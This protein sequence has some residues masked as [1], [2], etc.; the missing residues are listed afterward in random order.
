MQLSHLGRSHTIG[1][2]GHWSCLWFSSAMFG[3]ALSGGMPYSIRNTSSNSLTSGIPSGSPA[4]STSLVAIVASKAHNPSQASF[5]HGLL[6]SLS[7]QRSDKYFG[8]S[9]GVL[10]HS[11]TA[12]NSTDSPRWPDSFQASPCLSLVILKA[13]NNQIRRHYPDCDQYQDVSFQP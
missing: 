2:F 4:P 3:S 5:P 10:T 11:Q 1:I 7:I 9:S 12:P 13:D 8:T 6:I